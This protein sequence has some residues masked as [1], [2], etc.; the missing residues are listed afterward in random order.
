MTTMRVVGE[1][2]FW[3]RLTRVFPDKFHRAVKRLCV[4]CVLSYN[5]LQQL[6]LLHD[7]RLMAFFPGQMQKF[8]FAH[9]IP[10]AVKQNLRN[11][12]LS[13]VTARK[14]TSGRCKTYT[15]HNNQVNESKFNWWPRALQEIYSPCYLAFS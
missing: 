2:F 11:K 15:T 8:E 6:L 14:W 13:D 1:C 10:S 4:V 3:Y 9:I 5:T 7:I 12:W